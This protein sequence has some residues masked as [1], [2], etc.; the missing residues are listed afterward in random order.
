MVRDP[1]DLFVVLIQ[2]AAPRAPGSPFTLEAR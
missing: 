1:N 2:A